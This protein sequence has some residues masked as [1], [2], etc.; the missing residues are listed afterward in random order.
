MPANRISG[1]ITDRIGGRNAPA[2][3]AANTARTLPAMPGFVMIPAL[4]VSGSSPQQS[5]WVQD[6][7]QAAYDQARITVAA[8]KRI[9][10]FSFIWN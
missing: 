4:F 8:R 10:S 3:D 9:R 7:Y 2:S 6:V 5:S 1:V